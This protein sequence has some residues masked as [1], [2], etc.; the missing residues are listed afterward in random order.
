[1]GWKLCRSF[2]SPEL[3]T[4]SPASSS[5]PTLVSVWSGHLSAKLSLFLSSFS[6]MGRMFFTACHL[7]SMDSFHYWV[8]WSK[9]SMELIPCSVST[10]PDK[11]P[12]CDHQWENK[13]VQIQTF[14][15]RSKLDRIQIFV[16][17]ISGRPGQFKSPFSKGW[18]NNLLEFTGWSSSTTNWKER[19]DVTEE[20]KSLVEFMDV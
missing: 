7:P 17:L 1:M 10:V 20:R 5:S 19:W 2:Q 11:L 16:R 8:C 3:F 15:D 12:C 18:F 4:F 9:L 6:F 13:Y 14:S